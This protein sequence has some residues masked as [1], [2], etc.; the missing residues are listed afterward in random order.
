MDLASGSALG[1][2]RCGLLRS[3][4]LTGDTPLD[5]WWRMAVLAKLTVLAFRR[6]I[7][8]LASEH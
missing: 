2:H 5:E 8:K 7:R 4:L 3:F 6:A 1:S